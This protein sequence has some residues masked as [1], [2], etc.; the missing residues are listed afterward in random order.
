MQS[1]SDHLESCVSQDY[2]THKEETQ[3]NAANPTH[4]YAQ[5]VLQ[6]QKEVSYSWFPCWC[7]LL[8]CPTFLLIFLK[9][10]Y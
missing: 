3:P 8:L 2:C 1:D 10:L 7:V 9:I 6:I 5:C 4:Q